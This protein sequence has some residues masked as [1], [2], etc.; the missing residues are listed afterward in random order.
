MASLNIL[1]LIL[2]TSVTAVVVLVLHFIYYKKAKEQKRQITS[3]VSNLPGFV[4]K[5]KHDK[6]WTMIYLSGR[7]VEITG[8]EPSEFIDNSFITFNE[9]IK[10][11]YREKLYQSWQSSI[12]SK[13][14]FE[15]EYEIVTRSG[16]LKWVL[17][18]GAPVLDD[19]NEVLFLEGY[20]EDVS[21]TVQHR[22]IQ[23]QLYES[24][25]LAKEKAEQSEKLKMAFLANMSHEIR[26]P[27][28]GILGFM[29]LLKE[30]GLAEESR[31]EYIELVNISGQRLLTTINDIIEISKIESGE[32]EIK[33]EQVNIESV[34][35]FYYDFFKRETDSKGIYLKI[36]GQIAGDQAIILTDKHK[37]D[38]ILTNLIKN[39]IKFTYQGGIEFGN[40]IEQQMLIFYVKDSGR[41]IASER[42]EA[43]FERF[44]QADTHFSRSYEGSGLGLA[45]AKAYV[46]ALGG[47]IR[48]ESEPYKGSIFRFSIP[49][50]PFFNGVKKMDS[51]DDGSKTYTRGIKVI[52]AEDDE[53]SYRYIEKIIQADASLIMHATTG[54]ETIRMARENEDIALILMDLKMPDMDGLEATRRIRRFNTKVPII[55]QTAYALPGDKEKAKEA[56]CNDYLSKPV[57]KNDLIA[58]ISRYCS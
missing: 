47:T 23:Q 42:Q 27:M 53:I 36:G 50:L 52:V 32:R 41:G 16:E 56:G 2:I 14:M 54:V 17:E 12:M 6:D 46:D 18:R 21:E 20:I 11:E 55:A 58:M 48:V 15:E 4:Y 35:Q 24:M 8:Y 34:M 22:K 7:C 29:E 40:Y 25:L 9:I 49:Y 10:E 39:A 1:I 43:I 45:I 5:C 57:S 26:T 37:I 38:S 30:P 31:Q 3:M 13:T 44:I 51:I 19:R 33:I 28:N